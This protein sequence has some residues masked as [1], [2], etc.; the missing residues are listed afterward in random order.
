ML[1]YNKILFYFARSSYM[2]EFKMMPVFHKSSLTQDIKAVLS[3]GEVIKN[4]IWTKHMTKE[5]KKSELIF[6][7]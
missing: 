1:I 3:C 2:E 5:I 7:S 6:Y 4:N